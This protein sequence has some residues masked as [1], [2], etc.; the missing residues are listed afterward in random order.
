MK[1]REIAAQIIK[2][3]DRKKTKKRL[4]QVE[5]F[6]KIF[7]SNE[8][9]SDFEQ[10]FDTLGIVDDNAKIE[11]RDVLIVLNTYRES[12]IWQG[13]QAKLLDA[14]GEPTEL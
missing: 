5:I 1:H 10:L 8:I 11:K 2:D 12:I 7:A 13:Q 3:K 4:E 9:E 14:T 6:T